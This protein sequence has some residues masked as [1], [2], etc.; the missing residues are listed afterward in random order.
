MSRERSEKLALGLIFALAVATPGLALIQTEDHMRLNIQSV[1]QD[2]I[3]SAHP[4]YA[5]I[6]RREDGTWQKFSAGARKPDL[7]P[8][9]WYDVT[10]SA[11]VS[12]RIGY[13]E[14]APLIKAAKPV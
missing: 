9:R 4:V 14:R 13:T 11:P 12:N 10:V 1:E 3:R 2:H 5:V 8:G 7:V 6:A